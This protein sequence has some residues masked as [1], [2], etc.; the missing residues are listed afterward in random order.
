M[1]VLYGFYGGGGVF[2]NVTR[3]SLPI[4]KLLPNPTW[5]MVS[6]EKGAKHGR[7]HAYD[8]ELA[9][10]CYMTPSW[11]SLAPS[12]AA[13]DDYLVDRYRYVYMTAIGQGR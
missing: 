5:M 8:L 12:N 11:T 2:S 1:L 3:Q 9:K 13:A 7:Q 6:P 4:V 10:F